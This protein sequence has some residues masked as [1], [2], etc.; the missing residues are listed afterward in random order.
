ML[1]TL[2]TYE[3]WRRADTVQM[4]ATTDILNRLFSNNIPPV[5]LA[6]TVGLGLVD[7]LP[8]LKRHFIGEAAGFTSQP[9]L[10]QGEPV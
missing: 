6:R 7:R 8:G 1:D 10:L 4:A 9:K 3:R 2:Q 5:R